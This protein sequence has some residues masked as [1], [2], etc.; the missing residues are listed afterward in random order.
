MLQIPRVLAVLIS[1]FCTAGSV[2]LVVFWGSLILI[3]ML[4]ILL[5]EYCCISSI[6]GI[7][8][9]GTAKY[10][11]YFVRLV[12]PVLALRVLRVLGVVPTYQV[13]SKCAVYWKYEVYFDHLSVHRRF[14]NSIHILLQTAFTDGPT[15]ENWSKLPLGGKLEYLRVPAVFREYSQYLQVQHS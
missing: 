14:D 9:A 2:I 10:L 7:C 15:N 1:R 5:V 3:L 8:T 11:Q 4:Y 12:L 13:L 6:S